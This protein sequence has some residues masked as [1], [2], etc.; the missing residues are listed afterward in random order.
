MASMTAAF[1]VSAGLLAVASWVR[2]LRGARLRRVAAAAAV[3]SASVTV[4]TGDWSWQLWMDGRGADF[5]DVAQRRARPARRRGARG[6]PE[7]RLLPPWG[8]AAV[9]T[10]VV[11]LVDASRA[12]EATP[13]PADRRFVVA[14]VWYPAA[15]GA[16]GRAWYLGRDQEEAETVTAALAQV[17]GVPTFLLDEAARA[18]TEAHPHA[19][20]LSAVERFPVVLFSPG[21][22][23]VRS[24]GSLPGPRSRR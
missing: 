21:L 17:L 11:E 7:L 5:L 9:G 8:P 3:L 15:A 14:Q 10:L 13:D 20:P 12:E 1:L 4:A 2:G 24:G 18:R 23:G 22:A 19:E 16:G 6:L